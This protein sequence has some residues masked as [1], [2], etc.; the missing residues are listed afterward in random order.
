MTLKRNSPLVVPVAHEQ[1]GQFHA[2]SLQSIL[3]GLPNWTEY[4]IWRSSTENG[5]KKSKQRYSNSGRPWHRHKRNKVTL[6]PHFYGELV[7]G[8][9]KSTDVTQRRLRFKDDLKSYI[10]RAEFQSK[11]LAS[12]ASNRTNWPALIRK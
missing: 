12:A 1:L 7:Y 4:Q 6:R 11:Q 10:K 3:C 9:T 5:L 8:S 2:D